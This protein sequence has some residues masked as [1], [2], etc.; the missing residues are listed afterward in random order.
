MGIN[1]GGCTTTTVFC[2]G[3]ATSSINEKKTQKERI[4]KKKNEK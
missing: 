4:K 3:H 1:E 2:F